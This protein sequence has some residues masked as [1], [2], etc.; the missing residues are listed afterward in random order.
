MT[1]CIHPAFLPSFPSPP[2]LPSP[3]SINARKVSRL[4]LINR[5]FNQPLLLVAATAAASFNQFPLSF[6]IFSF[7]RSVFIQSRF[8]LPLFRI[9]SQYA[10]RIIRGSLESRYFIQILGSDPVI[11]Y[12]TSDAANIRRVITFHAST[13]SISNE[14]E[15]KERK[16]KERINDVIDLDSRSSKGNET[17]ISKTCI[18]ESV[19]ILDRRIEINRGRTIKARVSHPRRDLRGRGTRRTV[20]N[21]Q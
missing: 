17:C 11:K 15:K 5:T 21:C 3:L 12:F 10:R 20:T 16:K 19:R 13:L 2:F 7:Y 9:R 6:F 1:T 4:N 8:P 14:K 18:Y